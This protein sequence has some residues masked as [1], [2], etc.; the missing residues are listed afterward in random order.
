MVKSSTLGA[1]LSVIVLS[2]T[3]QKNAQA[4][5]PSNYYVE[6]PR[7]FYGGVVVGG[8]FTQVDGDSYAGYHKL[9]FNLGPILY[10]QFAPKIAGSIEILYS[11]KGARSTFA[12]P[13]T[14]KAFLITK[15]NINLNYVEIPLQLNYFDK[16]KSHFGGGISISR[17][18]SSKETIETNPNMNY[19][20]D[21]YPFKKMDYNFIIG[22]QLHLWKGLF[23]NLR[24]QYS[25]VPIRKDIDRE[26]GRGEQYNNM[27][28]L[29]VMYLFD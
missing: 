29:R 17:L 14:S 16:R 22:G 2:F 25:L 12:Q 10:A 9:G 8:N 19:D 27:W 3:F 11:Q 5:N 15:Q 4:Q 6:E 24:F 26:Y 7:T 21:K 18:I 28:T 1:I 13:S 23:A 20:Q